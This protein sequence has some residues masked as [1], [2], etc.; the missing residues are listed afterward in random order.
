MSEESPHLV[1]HPRAVKVAALRGLPP[2]NAGGRRP[3]TQRDLQ[4]HEASLIAAVAE[5]EF[6]KEPPGKTPIH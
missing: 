2:A 3:G 1:D 5:Q 6:L 4:S